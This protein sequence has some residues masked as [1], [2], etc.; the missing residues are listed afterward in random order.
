MRKGIVWVERSH[1]EGDC[2]ME[3]S[4][5]ERDRYAWDSR[6]EETDFLE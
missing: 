5:E 3:R 4:H 1:E 6:Q 2:G